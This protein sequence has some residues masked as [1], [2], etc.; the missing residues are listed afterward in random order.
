M[1]Y[2]NAYDICIS[3]MNVPDEWRKRRYSNSESELPVD[4]IAIPN[5]IFPKEHWRDYCLRN[6]HGWFEKNEGN[7]WC[8]LVYDESELQAFHLHWVKSIV[9]ARLLS[10]LKEIILIRKIHFAHRKNIDITKPKDVEG[11]IA[12]RSSDSNTRTGLRLL[13]IAMSFICFEKS[14][15]ELQI[16]LVKHERI[17]VKLLPGIE[18]F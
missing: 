5:P 2:G 8:K 4:E 16:L 17:S 18:I 9:W 10:L 14:P 6:I 15:A 3:Q 1:R 12:G 7:Y 13:P 11:N